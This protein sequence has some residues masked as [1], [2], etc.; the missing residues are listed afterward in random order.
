MAV[1]LLAG[2]AKGLL[3]KGVAKGAAKKFVT[4]KKK[5]STQRSY[6]T[7]QSRT[8][9][10]GKKV[11]TKVKPKQKKVQ[12]VNLPTSVY[13]TQSNTTSTSDTNVSFDSLGQQL[14]NINK[15]TKTLVDVEKAETKAKKKQNQDIRA[16]TR[17]DKLEAK[18]EE[19]ERKNRFKGILGVGG[20]IGKNFG[21]F[22]FLK[23]VALGGLVL[24]LLK[25]YSAIE[26]I[27][28]SLSTNFGKPFE[29]IKGILNGIAF[30]FG[31]PIKGALNLM[32]QAL[33][34]SVNLLRGA[35]KK[36]KPVF[37]KVFGGLGRGIVNF[38]KR[39]AKKAGQ[40]VKPG[41]G[42]GP[43]GSPRGSGIRKPKGASARPPKANPKINPKNFGRAAP[44]INFF[45]GAFKKLP[46]VG[47]IIGLVI[48]L[49]LGVPPDEA[50]VGAIGAS[51]GSFV[52]GSIGAALGLGVASAVTGFLGA[53]G[54]AILGDYLGKQL[55]RNLKN[56]FNT[57]PQ[58]EFD[59]GGVSSTGLTQDQVR[60]RGKLKVG[61]T[62]KMADGKSMVWGG[63]VVGFMTPEEYQKATGKTPKPI[64]AVTTSSST[65][66]PK[67]TNVSNVSGSSPEK[68][69]SNLMPSSDAKGLY[70]KLGIT[71]SQWKTYK[72]TLASIE[73]SGYGLAESYKAIGGTG[74]AYDGRYQMGD[75]AKKDA[76]RILGIPVPSRQEF[77]NNP[78]LQENMILAYTYAN[79][80][81]MLGQ[82]P[83]YDK[84]DGIERLTYLGFGHN[85]GWKNAVNWLNS[86]KTKDPTRDGF[87]TSGTKFTDA[88]RKS[89]G[90]RSSQTAPSMTERPV[91][92]QRFLGQ[93]ERSAE[94][95]RQRQEEAKLTAQQGQTLTTQSTIKDMYQGGGNTSQFPISSPY[96][97][98]IH[99][100]TGQRGSHHSG[101]DIAPNPPA[102]GYYVGLK[103]PGKVT[104]IDF[105]PGNPRGYGH[106][107]IITSQETGMSYMFAHL[108]KVMVKMGETYTGQPI[109]E[110]GNTGGSTGIHLHYEVYKGGK[111][112]PEV[113]PTPYLTLDLH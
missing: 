79:H 61:Q 106:F 67:N 4:G 75:L 7:T 29:L 78:Q 48:D 6:S 19:L 74:D 102:P 28:T 98:R 105:D 1:P 87:G 104:R 103:V 37:K 46:I 53:T 73:T 99:P 95:N 31:G 56:N 25:N 84:A 107:V 13:K 15:T 34:K 50:V 92:P 86:N 65:S 14:D 88:L 23:N 71:P 90:A 76:A 81:Y 97:E 45:R 111:D 41:A 62:Y 96:G 12:T 80:T 60:E 100:I 44:R 94:A 20:T 58:V 27:I 18:E 85:Q 11:K 30:T 91:S 43:K 42:G 47:P 69:V 108:A 59:E 68:Y 77:R 26:N 33:K 21:I 49:V 66:S 17:R 36:I 16:K 40:F 9:D 2:A 51:I 10:V 22:N 8:Q 64:K 70:N 5:Q 93:G 24:F 72:D 82:A 101:V 3:T 35:A 89:F 112:G 109:G 52:L 113:D 110:I 39:L 57:G 54:G 83:T 55:Y 63:D 38:A 32:Y